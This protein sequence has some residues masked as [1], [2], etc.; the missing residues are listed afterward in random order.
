[1]ST[2]TRPPQFRL[3]LLAFA[4]FAA[5]GAARAE[6]SVAEGSVS[7]GV[8]GVTG[9]RS[10]RA[11][12]GQYNS[13][14]TD[15][16]VGLFGVEYS[17]R[18]ADTGTSTTFSGV[19]LFGNTQELDFRWKRQ[20]NWKFSAGLNQS[21]RNE[22]LDLSTGADLKVKRTSLGVAYQ[23]IISRDLQFDVALS[24]EKKD[25]SRLFGIGMNC[26]S[27]VAPGCGGTTGT[28]TGWAVLF[29]PEPIDANHSQ[30]DARVSYATG[31]LRLSGGYYGS[32]Y[33]NNNGSLNPNVPATLNNALGTPLPPSAGLA[34]ILGQPVALPPDNQAHQLD[35]AGTYAFTP[36]AR[37]NFKLARGLATQQQDFAAAG[38]TGAPAGVTNL[39]GRVDTTLAQVG[40]S[41]RPT[42]KLSLHAKWRYEDRDDATAIAPYNI[43]GA[44][45]YTNRRLP[46]TKVRGQVQGNYQFTSDV[47]G[48]LAAD[49]EYIDRGVF[50]P[51]SAV[52]GI[53]ALR[54]E[55]EE[56]GVR[57]ELRRRL[58]EDFSGSISVS[59]HRRDGSNWLRDNSGLGVTEVPD[60]SDPAAGLSTAI[61][62]PTLADRQRD[63]LKLQADWQATES[64]TLQLSAQSGRDSFTTPSV[65]GLRNA[66]MDQANL[67]ATYAY[68]LAWSFTGSL[69]YGN[70]TL[71]QA[72]PDAA[73]VSFDNTSTGV[74]LGVS[75]KISS[76]FLVG[77]SLWF[78]DDRSEYAQ[79]LQP[80][81]DGATVALLA[82]T[83]GLPD[84]VFRQATLKLFGTYK[85]NKASDLRVDLVH[86]RST[87]TDWAWAYNGVPFRYSDGTT[88]SQQARQEATFVGVRYIYR[89]E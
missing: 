23:K 3:T 88:A 57:A 5:C 9:D 6:D 72:R 62:M 75:G 32:F 31:A 47:R 54:Q 42:T 76:A 1:M 30:I 63:K 34:G 36:S 70:E 80:T 4:V 89:W 78:V 2:L 49:Y 24:S 58:T 53:S 14:R 51:S 87:W 28:E 11:L 13:L 67:D 66:R 69:S 21:I 37:M 40:L 22:L 85:L 65:Y 16:A 50:T 12:F 74:G 83:G 84:I 26:P 68:S 45:V 64:M 7:A 8:G 55:T 35:I 60:A 82:G 27:A 61:F 59:S 73:I 48:A 77:G 56:T 46:S 52:A 18:D 19:D 33:N 15:R 71:R 81:A 17:R 41:A 38:L 39:G 86:Q 43:E 10:D 44:S 29:Q 20:G 25:G 79:T